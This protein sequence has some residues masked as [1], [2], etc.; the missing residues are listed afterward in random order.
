MLP[1]VVVLLFATEPCPSGPF[2]ISTQGRHSHLI[3]Y[4]QFHAFREMTQG[5]LQRVSNL[6]QP[7]HRRVDD[8]SL[9]PADVCSIEAALAAEALLRV[10]RPLTEFSHD[11]PD[12]SHFQIGRLEVDPIGWT[13]NR[14]FL[15]GLAG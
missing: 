9:D 6:P 15:D 12:G 5:G 11:G 4:P 1:L 8:P 2:G 14:P 7:P 10:A 13:K 3:S